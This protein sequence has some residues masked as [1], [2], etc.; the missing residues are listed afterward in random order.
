MLPKFT[1]TP[2]WFLTTIQ[3]ILTTPLD[4]P[5]RPPLRFELSNEAAIHNMH[6]LQTH[7][8]S[9]QNLISTYPGSSL[10]PGS[11][12]RPVDVL[13]P[14]LLHHH[15]WPQVSAI[16]SLGSCWPLLPITDSDRK[17]KNNEFIQRGKKTPG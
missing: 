17:A 15:S 12:F 6:L 8:D 1:E 3:Q 10:S 5:T 13:K 2:H 7:G 11:E 9:I 14:L 16:L 4:T